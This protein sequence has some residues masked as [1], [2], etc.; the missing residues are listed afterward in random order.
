MENT[1]HRELGCGMIIWFTGLPSSGKST[2]ASLAAMKLRQLGYKALVIEPYAVR[3]SLL[4]EEGWDQ[5]GVK[6]LSRA[7][8]WLGRLLASQQIIVL[9]PTVMPYKG[10]RDEFRKELRGF[11]NT[12]VCVEASVRACM[13]RDSKG[14]YASTQKRSKKDPSLVARKY[15]KPENECDLR[16]NTETLTPEEAAKILVDFVKEELRGKEAPI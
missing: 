8:I 6:K 14:I 1:Q 15:E 9:F 11:K 10:V 12:L 16:I 7:L 2:I 5:E 13:K 3:K 4:P